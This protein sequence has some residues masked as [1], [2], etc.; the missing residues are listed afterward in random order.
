MMYTF[1]AQMHVTFKGDA[2]PHTFNVV[3]VAESAADVVNRGPAIMMD[4]YNGEAKR[5]AFF[6]VRLK[7]RIEVVI[8]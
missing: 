6:G 4:R 1:E 2:M 8:Q 3:V 7:D 5:V